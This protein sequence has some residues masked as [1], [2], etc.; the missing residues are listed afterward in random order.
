MH[1]HAH[2]WLL[3]PAG[4]LCIVVMV[5]WLCHML[6][7]LFRYGGSAHVPRWHG[8]S[9]LVLS[10]LAAVAGHSIDHAGVIPHGLWSTAATISFAVLFLVLI[11]LD[12]VIGDRRDHSRMIP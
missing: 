4:V 10:T 12:T 5:A 8:R 6:F 2:D 11:L 1:E 9:N 7:L 3:A